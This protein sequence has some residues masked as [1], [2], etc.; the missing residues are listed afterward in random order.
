MCTDNLFFDPERQDWYLW[1]D[2]PASD[3]LYL[4]I[5]DWKGCYEVTTQKIGDGAI[6]GETFEEIHEAFAAFES[7][8]DE[9]EQEDWGYIIT[10]A[11]TWPDDEDGYCWNSRPVIVSDTSSGLAS[12][13]VMSPTE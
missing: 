4:R 8:R 3:S 1:I 10:L 13:D 7:A 11:L 2:D 5:G 9:Y 6:D 12:F